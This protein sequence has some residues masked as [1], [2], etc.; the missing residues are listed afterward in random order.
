MQTF[1]ECC[2]GRIELYSD[3]IIELS[4]LPPLVQALQGIVVQQA[5]A[6]RRGQAMQSLL[7]SC[8][9]EW[10][11]ATSRVNTLKEESESL[12]KGQARLGE[13]VQLRAAK[14]RNAKTL[15]ADIGDARKKFEEMVGL[16]CMKLQA[17]TDHL[18][19]TALKIADDRRAEQHTGWWWCHMSV[20][21]WDASDRPFA[22]FACAELNALLRDGEQFSR[23]FE[24]KEQLLSILR[25]C[26]AFSRPQLVPSDVF[27]ECKTHD[28]WYNEDFFQSRADATAQF[29]RRF[30]VSVKEHTTIFVRNVQKV[31]MGEFR[32]GQRTGRALAGTLSTRRRIMALTQRDLLKA[33][34]ITEI[35]QLS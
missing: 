33:S 19:T 12:T 26:N 20:S 16:L 22:N 18:T 1:R 28:V 21:V 27:L 5:L 14:E 10:Q 25:N 8:L 9:Q 17:H 32:S 7:R 4:L 24:H 13:L 29:V 15:T 3:L 30:K 31:A 34:P 35:S 23:T 11:F 6:L 2:Y